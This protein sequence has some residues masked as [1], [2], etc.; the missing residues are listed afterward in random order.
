MSKKEIMKKIENLINKKGEK[1]IDFKFLAE[2]ATK[3]DL[4]IIYEYGTIEDIKRL[5]HTIKVLSALSGKWE[6]IN[7]DLK[8]YV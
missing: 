3:E 7:I 8:K 4:M 2:H 6:N 5:N 1:Q